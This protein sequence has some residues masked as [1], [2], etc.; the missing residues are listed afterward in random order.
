[1]YVLVVV[2]MVFGVGGAGVDA[3]DG[4]NTIKRTDLGAMMPR[5]W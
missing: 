2:V 1:M 5:V 4:A 3:A